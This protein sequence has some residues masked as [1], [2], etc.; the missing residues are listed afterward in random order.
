MNLK[1]YWLNLRLEKKNR[2]KKQAHKMLLKTKKRDQDAN[3]IFNLILKNC[4]SYL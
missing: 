1:L 2:I 3:E 4:L